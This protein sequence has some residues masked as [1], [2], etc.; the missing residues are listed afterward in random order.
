MIDEPVVIAN[1]GNNYA[2]MNAKIDLA[3]RRIRVAW[4]TSAVQVQ[5]VALKDQL[6]TDQATSRTHIIATGCI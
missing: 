2:G 1:L 5:F 6:V 3:N 4:A